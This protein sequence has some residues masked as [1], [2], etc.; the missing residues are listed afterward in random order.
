[1]FLFFCVNLSHFAF[2]KKGCQVWQSGACI[3]SIFNFS[4]SVSLSACLP[5]LYL[6]SV[7][8]MNSEIFF[9]TVKGNV[10]ESLG[11][12][13]FVCLSVCIFEDKY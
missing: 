6:A 4:Y 5:S 8:Y 9:L 12:G 3:A 10:T 2:I 7:V 13:V 1:M 11:K